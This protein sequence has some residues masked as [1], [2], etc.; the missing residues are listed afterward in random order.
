M[1]MIIQTFS[2]AFAEELGVELIPMGIEGLEA[3]TQEEVS[4]IL[5]QDKG[6]NVVLTENPDM[7]FLKKFKATRP[8]LHL[9][10]LA[11][12][13]LKPEELRNL[14]SIG[15]TSIINY[16]ENLSAIAEEVVK[17]IIQNNIRT[18]E[19]RFHVR[20]QPRDVENVKGAVFLKD[21]RRFVRGDILDISAGGL[22]IKLEDSLDASL[23]IPMT[24]YDPLLI[25][26]K[27]MQI[28]TLSRM[29]GKRNDVA[30]FKFENVEA[31]DM[32]KIAAYIHKKITE[33]TK[34]LT[35]KV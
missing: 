17:D 31:G 27:G 21:M 4:G 20:V 29:V 23:L 12:Q 7:E 24:L 5:A 34:K 18:D 15:I 33:N 3:L 9:F 28:K 30:G 19:R 26:M 6:I 35:D 16:S 25:S 2:H 1:R 32:K 22:A 11:H 8:G 14:Q 10:L 13:N